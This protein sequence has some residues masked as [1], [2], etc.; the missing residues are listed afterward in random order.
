MNMLSSQT[1]QSK[2]LQFQASHLL[3]PSEI[4]FLLSELARGR[5]STYQE[6]Y[7][8]LKKALAVAL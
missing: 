4:D 2:F 3:E 5:L 6:E 7:G 8:A 1:N